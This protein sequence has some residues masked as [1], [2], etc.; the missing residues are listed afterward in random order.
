MY[1]CED[2]I[3][4]Q[5]ASY[6]DSDL[7]NTIQSALENADR[8]DRL[9]FGICWQYDDLT[10]TDLDPYIEDQRFQITQFYFE[11]SM[12]CCWARN[13]TNLLYQNEDF[14]LQIDAHTRFAENWDTRYINMLRQLDCDKPLL[15]TYPAPFVTKNGFDDLFMDRGI[16]RLKLNRLRKNLTTF[17][18]TEPVENTEYCASSQ[19]I[20]AGQIFTLGKF[21]KE[22]EY[23][24]DLY[25]EGEE[26]SLAARA[27]THGYDMFCP[28][29]NLIW[30]RYNHEMPTHWS[31]HGESLQKLA[32][33]RIYQLLSGNH[34]QLGKYGL[35][36]S[37]SLADFENLIDIN[38]NERLQRVT[39]PT[40]FQKE[41]EIDVAGIED[42]DDYMYWIFSLKNIDD[43]EIYRYDIMDKRVLRKQ[44]R[45]IYVDMHLE[46]EPVSYMIWPY[47]SGIGYLEQLRRD[48]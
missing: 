45:K 13:Q 21:C 3:F 25:F 35:G 28:N 19:F 29:E 17:L 30:H 18:G 4:V 7:P 33:S 46:D 41:V 15:T 44:I 34:E 27:Y 37:R 40:H 42:R 10:Y 39:K 1:S 12:G 6:R 9:R 31:D 14:T 20:G 5:I 11:D 48:L 8:P 38:F 2:S 36:S 22:V 26:I 23:D 32:N 24:P 43:D 47:V 16:Q